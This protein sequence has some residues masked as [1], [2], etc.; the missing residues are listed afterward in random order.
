MWALAETLLNPQA[1]YGRL[2]ESNQ[3]H[4]LCGPPAT[5]ARSVQIS[6]GMPASSAS[7]GGNSG[8]NKPVSSTGSCGK[9]RGAVQ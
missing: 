8:P 1:N 5:A 4:E 2:H 3:K 7:S 6:T 9:T